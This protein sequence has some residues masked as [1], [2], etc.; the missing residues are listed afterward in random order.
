MNSNTH[1]RKL[2]V[3]KWVDNI[4]YTIN[5]LGYPS[6][7]SAYI[8]NFQSAVNQYMY[9]GISYEDAKGFA[10]ESLMCHYFTTSGLQIYD[11]D[12]DFTES[13]LNESWAEYLPNLIKYVPHKSFYLKLPHN[14]TSEGTVIAVVDEDEIEWET[15]FRIYQE[16]YVPGVTLYGAD[17]NLSKWTFAKVKCSNGTKLICRW[18]IPQ[19]I[20]YMSDDTD[21]GD[22]PIEL[23]LNAIAYVCSVNSDINLEY[24][25][26]QLAALNKKKKKR[27]NAV[28]YSVGYN[29]GNTLREYKKYVKEV[30]EPS[31]HVRPHM[32]RA[33]WH[34]YWVGP[35]GNQRIELRW[36]APTKVG[37]DEIE[38]ATLHKV[39]EQIT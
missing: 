36:I 14:K 17:C 38:S 9:A 7:E 23:A 35:K 16:E 34:H 19:K 8:D 39:Q 18:A 5:V 4:L 37:F 31:S 13:I 10:A 20:E 12:T 28:W 30:S 32:R 15:T 33:H 3:E 1:I 29:I 24:T 26:P 27:S 22:Y 21:L 2:T 6:L 11:F 25:P